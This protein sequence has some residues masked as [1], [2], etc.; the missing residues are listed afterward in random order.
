M[1][2]LPDCVSDITN[3][4]MCLAAFI[5]S[6]VGHEDN[7]KSNE[8]LYVR[9]GLVPVTGDMRKPILDWY[10]VTWSFGCW[11]IS[12]VSVMPFG[13]GM[14]TVFEFSIPN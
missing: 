12:F 13:K 1:K 2:H 9:S 10:V 6:T 11:V 7:F 14:D 8:I 4:K 3:L 5:Y